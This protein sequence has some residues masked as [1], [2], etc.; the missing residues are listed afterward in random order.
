MAKAEQT[1]DFDNYEADAVTLPR[2][3]A[4]DNWFKFEKVGDMVQGYIRDV[5]YRP[6]EGMFKEQRGITLQQLDGTLVNVGMKRLPFVLNKTDDLRIGD[7][8]TVKLEEEKPSTVKGYNATKIFGFYAKKKS[9]EGPTLLE[10]ENEDIAKQNVKISAEEGE[11][12]GVDWD[13]KPETKAV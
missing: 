6:A 8:L 2:D 9:A 12:D 13:A 4:W 11:D 10:L 5:F 7:A 3:K 1:G